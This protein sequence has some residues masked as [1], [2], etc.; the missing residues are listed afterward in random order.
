MQLRP[1]IT[2]HPR[3]PMVIGKWCN[4]KCDI[5]PQ[6][7]STHSLSQSWVKGELLGEFFVV[8]FQSRMDACC[9][10]VDVSDDRIVL[11]D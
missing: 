4:F 6:P 11:N 2:V 7:T 5:E 3:H 10:L 8:E 9:M 1:R